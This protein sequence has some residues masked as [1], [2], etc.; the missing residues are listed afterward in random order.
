[1]NESGPRHDTPAPGEPATDG[2]SV[3]ALQQEVQFLRTLLVVSL[4]SLILLSF[5]VNI[6]VFRQV[7]I[8]RK[9]LDASNVALKEY[10]TKREPLINSFISSLQAF[11]RIHTDLI[12]VLERYGIGPA[13]APS[14]LTPLAAPPGSQK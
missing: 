6:Y 3:A 12:P 5:S 1:M 4:M 7:S 13:A 8:I 2:S 10:Q 9:E 14:S 11:S